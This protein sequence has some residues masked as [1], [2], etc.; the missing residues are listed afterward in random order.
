VVTDGDLSFIIGSHNAELIYRFLEAILLVALLIFSHTKGKS[1]GPS[2][3]SLNS[4]SSKKVY[5]PH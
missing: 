5:T 4:D 2:E 1:T 3:T